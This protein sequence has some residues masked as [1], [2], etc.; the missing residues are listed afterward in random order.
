MYGIIYK[1]TN[2]INGKIYIGQ[3]IHTFSSRYCGDISN[4]KNEHLRRAIAYYGK[5]AFRVDEVFDTA[6]SKE[7]LDEK[8]R[9]YISLYKSNQKRYG[10]NL[11]SGGHNGTHAEET[12]KR[13]GDAQKG[14]LNHMFGKYGKD[15]PK[16]S[17]VG[18][19]CSFCGKPIEVLQADIRRSKFHYCSDECRKQSKLHLKKQERKRVQVTCANC[20]KPFETF[21]SKAKSRKYMY[22]SRECQNEHFKTLFS[23]ENN[24]NFNNHKLA[25]GNNGRAKKVLCVTTGE[26][27]D[28]AIDAGKKYGIKRGLIPACCRGAQKTAGGKEWK[29]L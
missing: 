18:L 5:D 26:V 27:F 1:I 13:I 19:S 9:F 10:Y 8:E 2:T 17:R 16:Y 20:G 12:K 14:E 24:P 25:G 21:P 3:T 6:E 22:C 7:E 15:N 4:T 23:G 29:Y 11:M 28:C